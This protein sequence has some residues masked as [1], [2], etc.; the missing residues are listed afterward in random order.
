M[1]VAAAANA[2]AVAVT[3]AEQALSEVLQPAAMSTH[4]LSLPS[5]WVEDPAGWFQHA[6]AEFTRA[7]SPPTPMSVTCTLSALCPLKFTLLCVT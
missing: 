3:A 1:A 7:S 6:E 4:K 2:A 5:F